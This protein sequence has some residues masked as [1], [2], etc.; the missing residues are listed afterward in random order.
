LVVASSIELA[1][2][3]KGSR[4]QLKAA[5]YNLK[6]LVF[7]KENWPDS[8]VVFAV[9]MTLTA[10]ATAWRRSITRHTAS[11]MQKDGLFEVAIT[12][13]YARRNTE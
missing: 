12:P 10:R 9:K 4:M 1:T 3:V 6:R 8:R 11:I 2:A 7:L 5:S 13:E